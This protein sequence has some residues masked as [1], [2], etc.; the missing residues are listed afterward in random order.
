MKIEWHHV[1]S[2]VFDGVHFLPDGKVLSANLVPMSSGSHKHLHRTLDIDYSLIRAFRKKH[3]WKLTKDKVYYE[4]LFV[5][6]R[7]YFRRLPLLSHDIHKQH[8]ESLQGQCIV[9]K[10]LFDY[11]GDLFLSAVFLNDLEK[12]E[13]YLNIYFKIF[14]SRCKKEKE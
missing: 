11:K 5:M 2:L 9:L 12:F 8:A 1:I 10:E 3:A 7:M 6:I 4:D 14:L 13:F